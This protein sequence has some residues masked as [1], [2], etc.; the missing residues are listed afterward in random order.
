MKTL[1]IAVV[2][3]LPSIA[4]ASCFSDREDVPCWAQV[5]YIGLSLVDLSQTRWHQD[6]G[7]R[8]LN[9]HIPSDPAGINRNHL[10]ILVAYV[11]ATELLP[12]PWANRLTF[13][14]IGASAHTVWM[15]AQLG[16][17]ATW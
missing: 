16:V 6:H 4:A 13:Y 7:H 2:L 15:N 9:P 1:V 5:T 17:Q 10:G 8:E 14:L 12:A 11:V 3:F